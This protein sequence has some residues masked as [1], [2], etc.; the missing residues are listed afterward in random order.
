MKTGIFGV[1]IGASL[2]WALGQTGAKP[3]LA[4][5]HGGSH[6]ASGGHHLMA[7]STKFGEERQQVTVLDPSSRVMSVYHVS[8]RSGEITLRSVRNISWDLRMQE[9]NSTNPSPREIR[10]HTDNR[11]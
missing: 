6:A 9:F 3:P 4:S 10:S 8:A 5:A 11:K 1:L 7:M 2:V